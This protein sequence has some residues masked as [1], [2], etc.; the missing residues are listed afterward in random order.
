V[1]KAKES[2]VTQSGK[3]LTIGSVAVGLAVAKKL[4]KPE[5]IIALEVL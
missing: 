4:P 2:K 5:L 1:V 3:Y